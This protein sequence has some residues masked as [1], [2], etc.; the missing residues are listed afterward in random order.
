MTRI[1]WSVALATLALAGCAGSLTGFTPSAEHPG[2]RV[3]FGNPDPAKWVVARLP[4]SEPRADG[5]RNAQRMWVCRRDACSGNAAVAI[6]LQP[7]PTRHPDRKTL[8]KMAKFMPAQAK[9]Q[10]LMMEAASD[11]EER[12]TPL[13]SKVTEFRGYPAILAEAKRTSKSKASYIARGELFI[14]V[15]IVRVISVAPERAQA[16]DHLDAFVAALDILDVPAADEANPPAAVPVALRSNGEAPAAD[17]VG[18]AA[19]ESVH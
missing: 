15:L 7:S 8:E 12:M 1:A 18:T 16:K 4:A 13:S 10:D 17:A 5:P 19:A 3:A 6:Q 11:G 2:T 14:G 9:A